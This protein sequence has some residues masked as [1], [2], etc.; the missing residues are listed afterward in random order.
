LQWKETNCETDHRQTGK[1]TS[2]P[3]K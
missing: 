3:K 1:K 2:A